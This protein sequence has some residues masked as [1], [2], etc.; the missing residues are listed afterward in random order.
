ML[1]EDLGFGG[2]LSRNRVTGLLKIGLLN[3]CIILTSNILRAQIKHSLDSIELTRFQ[4]YP[5]WTSC[6]LFGY[7]SCM[8]SGA[9][10]LKKIT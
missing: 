5:V 4:Y 9:K 6:M 8:R 10:T 3:Q 2:D 7:I 1:P